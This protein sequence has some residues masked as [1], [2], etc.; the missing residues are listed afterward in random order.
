MRKLDAELLEQGQSLAPP[1]S[2]NPPSPPKKAD[3]RGVPPTRSGDTFEN[4]DLVKAPEMQQAVRQC[5][6]VARGEVWCAF[7]LGLPGT[8]KTHLAIAAM[9]EYTGRSAFWKVPDFLAFLRGRIPEGDSESIIAAYEGDFLLVLDD[10]GAENPTDW[11][12]EQLYRILDRRSDERQP[13]IITSNQPQEGIDERLRSRFR[14]GYVPCAG[15]D[16]RGR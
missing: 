2:N 10:L 4:F 8:G 9:N 12:S 16:Q 15:K 7:L 14:E 3:S 5:W 6:S 13:T 1:T 11:A